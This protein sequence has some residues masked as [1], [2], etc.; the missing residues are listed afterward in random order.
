MPVYL[1]KIQLYRCGIIT[2]HILFIHKIKSSANISQFLD[3]K[4]RY[5]IS[6]FLVLIYTYIYIYNN[7]KEAKFS[8]IFFVH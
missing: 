7:N 2:L 4:I 1:I 3:R 6:K 5:K 8:A